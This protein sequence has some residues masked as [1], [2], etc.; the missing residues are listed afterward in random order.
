MRLQRRPFEPGPFSLGRWALPVTA[1]AAAWVVFEL[2]NIAWPR[3]EGVPWYQDWAVFLMSGIVFA[4]G[5]AAYLA[6]R[7][8]VLAAEDRLEA[9]PDAVHWS[10]AKAAPRSP[11]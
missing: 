3:A 2:V 10:Q 8:K 7:P 9:D 1:L 5:V 4:L 6:V 11:A